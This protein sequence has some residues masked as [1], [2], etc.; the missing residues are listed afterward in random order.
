MQTTLYERLGGAHGIDELV[1]DIVAAHMENSI[2]GPRFQPYAEKPEKLDEL[3]AHLAKFLASGSGGPDEY[4]GRSMPDAHEGMNI[5][6]AEY[7]AA[8]DDIMEVLEDHEIDE[9][10]QKDM[11]A[12]AYSLKDDIVH[13]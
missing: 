5:S 11:L 10:T 8:V 4:E 6:T 3:K 12:I 2:I 7:I 9:D 13:L 1:D